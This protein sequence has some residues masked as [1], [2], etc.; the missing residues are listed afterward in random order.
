MLAL[1][2]LFDRLLRRRG[3]YGASVTRDPCDRVDVS[4]NARAGGCKSVTSEEW[5][6]GC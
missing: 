2:D 1:A 4:Q 5:I 6:H 3:R